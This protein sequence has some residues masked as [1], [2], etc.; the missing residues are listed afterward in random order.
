MDSTKSFD[1]TILE[2]VAPDDKL[3]P[4][5]CSKSVLKKHGFYE[6]LMGR[7]DDCS[8]ER[9]SGMYLRECIYRLLNHIDV[10]PVCKMCGKP[11][12]FKNNS[13]PTYCSRK[14]SNNDPEV[15][16]R[17]S[18]SCSVS[19]KKA[20]S[21]N[22]DE[23]KEK[24]K[25]TLSEKYGI[26]SSSSPFSIESVR[27]RQKSTVRDRYGVDNV[28]QLEKNQE[29]RKEVQRLKSIE[30]QS[31]RGIEI[32]YLPNGRYLVRNCCPIH[33]SLEYLRSDFNNRFRPDRLSVSNPCYKCNPYGINTS[34]VQRSLLDFIRSIYGGKI[35][36]N[37]RVALDGLEIDIYLP[38]LK[39][40][41]EFNGDYWHMNPLKYGYDSVNES[42]GMK[43]YEKWTEDR[44][45]RLLAASKGITICPIWEHDYVVN[46]QLVLIYVLELVKRENVYVDSLVKLKN[47]IDSVRTDYVLTDDMVFDFPELR[48]VYLDGFHFNRMTIDDGFLNSVRSETKRTMFVYDYEINDDRKF[49]VISSDIRYALGKICHRIYAR[50]CELRTMGNIDSKE[51][52]NEN[53]LFGFRPASITIGLY[54][55]DE[56]VMVYSFGYNFYGRKGDT[57][58]IRVCTKKDTQVIGGSSKCL[59][60]YLENYAHEGENIVFYVDAIH[61]TGSSMREFEFIRHEYGYMNYWLDFDKRGTAFNRMPSR[62]SYIQGLMKCGRLVAVPT[63][64]V[65]VYRMTVN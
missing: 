19:L 17:I 11:V 18:K 7:Y 14:C 47:L 49:G 28:L 5:R 58:I 53:S 20:Y 2:Y 35:I 13:Y 37:D 44:H 31:D 22:G 39:L 46:H 56:L 23:I 6:Y 62:N 45:K 9:D 4:S 55:E 27:E 65:D 38:D 10:L 61:H 32:E 12:G 34:G 59:S 29:R 63:F 41:F 24:R 3:I 16:L 42:T 30:Y 1:E 36:E 33:G 15:K 40:G 64:G 57:E 52:L 43:A 51:F 60:Y 48:I 26:D 8:S 54:Y 25:N 50:K 21:D